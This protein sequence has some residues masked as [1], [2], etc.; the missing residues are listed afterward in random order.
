MNDD[1]QANIQQEFKIIA[2]LKMIQKENI[3]GVYVIPSYESSFVWFGVIFVRSGYYRDGIFRFNISL[4]KDF[5]NTTDVPTVIYQSELIH[6]LICPYTGI[7]NIADAFPTWNPSEHHLWQLLKYIQFIFAHP[8][9]CLSNATVKISNQE[10]AELIRTQKLTE[11]EEKIKECVRISKDKIYDDPPTDDK[12]Y[13][14]FSMFDEEIHRLVLEKIKTKCETQ[15]V[16][17]P[18]SGLSWVNEGE[19]KALGK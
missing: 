19:F 8:V 14:T 10:A 1:L 5:P 2:E 12:H 17:P 11:F 4:P 18:P 13:I 7:L 16:S 9:A 6:P 3:A 15:S